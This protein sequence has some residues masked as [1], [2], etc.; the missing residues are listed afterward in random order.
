MYTHADLC[1]CMAKPI[2]YCKV[3]KKLIKKHIYLKKKKMA[4]TKS[5]WGYGEKTNTCILLIGL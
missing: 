3:K 2:E 5:S 4:N 1:W